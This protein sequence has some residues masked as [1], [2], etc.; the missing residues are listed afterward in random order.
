VNLISEKSNPYVTSKA[1]RMREKFGEKS[2][3]GQSARS[4]GRA[5]VEDRLSEDIA[6]F[7]AERGPDP[8]ALTAD[9]EPGFLMKTIDTLG[10]ILTFNF[11]IIC[12]FFT[13][14]LVG[15]GAQFGADN[16]TIINAFRSCWD[17]LILPLLSTHMALTFLSFGLEKAVNRETA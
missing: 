10:T 12:L 16:V 8:S 7:K 6:R 5:G 17:Y 9:E 1:D 13:W 4:G 11:G 15:V 3:V 2:V 14:F